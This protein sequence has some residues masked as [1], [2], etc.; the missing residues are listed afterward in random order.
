MFCSALLQYIHNFSPTYND[1]DLLILPWCPVHSGVDDNFC[2]L[3]IATDDSCRVCCI[4]LVPHCYATY[5]CATST[6]A[7][8]VDDV[9]YE[10]CEVEPDALE[11]ENPKTILPVPTCV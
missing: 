9:T 11:N 3:S 7:M 2:H 8:F 4:S 5:D 10:F 1:D 6:F